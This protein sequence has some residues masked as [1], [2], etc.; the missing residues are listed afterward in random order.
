MLMAGG[1]EGE[2]E[3]RRTTPCPGVLSRKQPPRRSPG[4][5]AADHAPPSPICGPPSPTRRQEGSSTARPSSWSPPWSSSPVAGS[6]RR[7][8][9]TSVLPRCP[10]PPSEPQVP[11]SAP[12]CRPAQG[13]RPGKAQSPGPPIGPSRPRCEG[14]SAARTRLDHL[15]R[16]DPR[17]G[18]FSTLSCQRQTLT[19]LQSPDFPRGNFYSKLP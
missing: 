19:I 5:E 18:P 16:P 9:R 15:P 1:D 6:L 4:G 8:V 17:E 11:V 2:G 12:L 13:R 3:R 7:S 14:W 10:V